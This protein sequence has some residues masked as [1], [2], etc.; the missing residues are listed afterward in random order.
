MGRWNAVAAA[1]I[2]V[3]AVE[4]AA[5]DEGH[6]HDPGQ[7]SSMMEQMKR[8]H[9]EHDHG[10]DLAA[11]ER[12][13]PEEREK[14]LA[15]LVDLGLGLPPMDSERGRALFVEKGCIVCHRVNGVGG[16]LGPAF[17]ASEMPVP[18]N[19]FEFAARMWRGAAAMVQMQEDML[20]APIELSGQELA[21]IVAFVHD[22]AEQRKLTAEQ[23]PDAFSTMIE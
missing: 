17:V 14:V 1:V 9:A 23:V 20:G 19:A 7:N 22:E 12:L 4:H 2:A 13:T 10:H 11:M 5:A 16:E 6:A 21:D 18:M 15:E 3:M 8:M